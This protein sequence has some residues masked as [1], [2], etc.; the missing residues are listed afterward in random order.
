MIDL[1]II[2][3]VL[4]FSI[5]G[6]YRGFIKTVM[7]LLASVAA[8]VL[9][10]LVYPAVNGFLKMT[11][12]YTY[13]NQWIEK[14][15]AHIEFGTGIQTQGNVISENITWIPKILSEQIIK[16]NNAEVYKVLEVANVKE[17]V[18]IYLTNMIIGIASILVIWLILK[19]LITFFLTTTHSIVSHT[20]V[21]SSINKLGGML[22][23]TAKGVLGIWI[24]CL[25]VPV[26]INYDFFAQINEAVSSSYL[27]R[28][29]YE[30]NMI[31]I[32]FKYIFSI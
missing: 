7:T 10:F 1:V 6:Y 24:I 31:I 29:L 17:Y 23:G 28:W 19:L 21:L 11:P 12:L 3:L 26:F 15:I 9:S 14:R 32:A 16:N 4:F 20:P 25:L 5:I 18:S 30:N 2:I 13:M 22:V 27:A 8:L